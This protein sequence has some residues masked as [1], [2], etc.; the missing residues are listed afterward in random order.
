[1]TP[2]ERVLHAVRHEEADRVPTG[3]WQYGP[4]IGLPVL[5]ETCRCWLGGL[6]RALAYWNGQRDEITRQ[7]KTDLVKL[8]KHFGWDAVLLH[9]VIGKNTV[10]SVPEK[11]S[12]N[13]WR[14]EN[15]T[16]LT[17]SPETDRL[18]IT[19]HGASQTEQKRMAPEECRSLPYVRPDDSEL[20]LVRHLVKE[21]GKTHFLFSAPLQGHPQLNFSDMTRNELDVWMDLYE[22]KKLFKDNLMAQ[23]ESDRMRKA[24]EKVAEEGLDGVANSWDFGMS[25]GPFMSPA[26]FKEV[27]FPYMKKYA[28]IAHDCGLVLLWHSCGNNQELLPMIAEAGVDV[29]Q[30]IQPEM[31]IVKMKELWGDKITLWGG[32]DAGLLISGSPDEIYE[33]STNV[34]NKCK[35]G[36]GYIYGTSHSI[37]PGSKPENYNTMLKALQSSGL[38]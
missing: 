17:Y 28:E 1:M 14:Y 8:T 13:Q 10:I 22:D 16:E 25:T 4:E 23:I 38:Y 19:G 36:G 33:Y 29:Y 27:I 9:N 5:G 26:I 31:N 2:K 12:E 34:I 3:E 18:F 30:S 35:S 24:V 6:D 32:V 15:G 7:R 20:E 37:M 11:S 21:L